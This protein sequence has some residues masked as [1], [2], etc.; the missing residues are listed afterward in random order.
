MVN[1]KN[2][3]LI[4]LAAFGLGLAGMAGFLLPITK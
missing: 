2:T 1:W 4:G 3:G